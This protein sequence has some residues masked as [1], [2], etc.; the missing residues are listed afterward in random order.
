MIEHNTNLI[1]LRL[2]RDFQYH[3]TPLSSLSA[4]SSYASLVNCDE[5]ISIHNESHHHQQ[6][7]DKKSKK[8]SEFLEIRVY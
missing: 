7:F 8:N 4:A 1:V 3:Q 6:H 5:T 2:L